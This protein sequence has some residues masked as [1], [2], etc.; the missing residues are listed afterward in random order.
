V[1]NRLSRRTLTFAVRLWA[2]HLEQTSP[3][4]GGEIEHVGTGEQGLFREPAD[5]IRFIEPP[6]PGTATHAKEGGG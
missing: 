3:A 5:A 2:E 6:A 4:L 1:V